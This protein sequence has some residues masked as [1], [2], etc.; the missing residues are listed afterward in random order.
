MSLASAFDQADV[1][2]FIDETVIDPA[3]IINIFAGF[4]IKAGK[5]VEHREPYRQADLKIIR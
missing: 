5:H 4:E 1:L 3:K 2:H